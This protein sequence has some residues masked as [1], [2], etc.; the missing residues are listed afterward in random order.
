MRI[1]FNYQTQKRSN[2]TMMKVVESECVNVGE[3]EEARMCLINNY[4]KRCIFKR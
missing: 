3:I 1:F 2:A 4:D